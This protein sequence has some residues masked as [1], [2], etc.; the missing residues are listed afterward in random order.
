[1]K[2]IVC[3]SD[4]GIVRITS[5][6]PN[7]NGSHFGLPPRE[8][9]RMTGLSP[10][11]VWTMTY[12]HRLHCFTHETWSQTADSRGALFWLMWASS[13][14]CSETNNE[15]LSFCLCNRHGCKISSSK[16]SVSFF[17][18]QLSFPIT[19]SVSVRLGGTAE[20]IFRKEHGPVLWL[21]FPP[22]SSK[23]LPILSGPG[24]RSVHVRKN[25]IFTL[26]VSNASY[27]DSGVYLYSPPGEL[28]FPR[29]SASLRT[30][31]VNGR[32]TPFVRPLL[33][34]LPFCLQNK[35]SVKTSAFYSPCM[36]SKSYISNLG[37]SS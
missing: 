12:P 26:R 17:F 5:W 18:F 13:V 8:I 16:F 15:T 21:F 36:Q 4:N 1:M 9:H 3:S 32:W 22:N 24:R 35:S 6:Y 10:K 25:R 34:K 33:H 28:R 2:S 30:L 20:L 11:I 7:F 23:G 27:A 14:Q 31:V 37:C 29:H 19:A